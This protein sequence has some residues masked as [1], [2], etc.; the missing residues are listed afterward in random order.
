MRL[1]LWLR[2]AGTGAYPRAVSTL[3]TPEDSKRKT[4]VRIDELK[5]VRLLAKVIIAELKT[6]DF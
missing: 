4:N 6:L 3:L 2:Q 1:P 5:N